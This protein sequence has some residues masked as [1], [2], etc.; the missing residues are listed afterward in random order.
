MGGA[1]AHGAAETEGAGIRWGTA[2]AR[3]VLLATVLGSG[4]A[5]LDATSSN[6]ALPA[7]GQDLDTGVAALQWTINAYALTLAALIILGGALGDR[8]G[9]RRVFLVGVAWFT[10]ASLLC[11]LAPNAQTLIAARALQGIGGALM[12]PGSL[13]IIQASFAPRDRARAVG[14]WSG[15]SGIAAAMGPLVGG[16]LV[17]L[18][19]WRL[20]FLTNVPVA[21]VVVWVTLRHVPESRDPESVRGLDIRGAV[22]AA[23]GLAGVSWALIDLGDRG[24]AAATL[25]V[26]AAGVFLLLAF[27][28]SQRRSPHPMVPPQLFASRQFTGANLVTIA[29]YA[30]LGGLFFLLFIHL[31]QVVGYS[32]VEAGLAALPVTGLML[33]LSARAGALAERIGPR[34]PMTMGPLLIAAGLLLHIRIGPGAD[35]LTTVLPAVAVFGLGLA[36]TVAPLTATVLAAAE[37]RFVGTASGVNNAFARTAGL[38]AVAALPVVSGL[39]GDAYLDASVF[40]AGFERAMLISAAIAAAGGL[41]AWLTIRNTLRDERPACPSSRLDRRYHCAVDGAPLA[42]ADEARK[43]GERASSPQRSSQI[44]PRRSPA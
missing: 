32:P 28:L 29:V 17:E 11:G 23:T 21:A 43:I 31:Q 2:A 33:I 10:V 1:G 27:A 19:T 37:A 5:F 42:T 38:L 12:T 18:W 30:A 40:A 24:A 34:L 8:F 9:R 41:I 25:A 3:W 6:V 4:L 16:W 22:L 13:A 14:A 7:I 39:T 20:I 44:E 35:Y 26:G 36:L 15:L